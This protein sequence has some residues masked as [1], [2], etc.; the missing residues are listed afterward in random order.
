MLSCLD[1]GL[2]VCRGMK[3]LA[4]LPRASTFDVI[5]ANRNSVFIC[6]YHR[7]IYRVSVAAVVLTTCAISTLKL[8]TNLRRKSHCWKRHRATL[9]CS[10]HC[11][12]VWVAALSDTHILDPCWIWAPLTQSQGNWCHSQLA[13]DEGNPV[14]PRSITTVMQVQGKHR[15]CVKWKVTWI[16][17]LVSQWYFASMYRSQYPSPVSKAQILI[18]LCLRGIM[19]LLQSTLLGRT[20]NSPCCKLLYSQQ[21]LILKWGAS[22]MQIVSLPSIINLWP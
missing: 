13:Q 22:F 11:I 12:W 21:V 16:P 15:I 19:P 9:Q 8:S 4:F 20:F 6:V 7:N 2:Q 1:F 17:N 3:V 5:H 10:Q 14:L 18:I